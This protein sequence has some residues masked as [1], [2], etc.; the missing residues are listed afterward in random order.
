MRHTLLLASA[1][2]ALM[3]VFV[4]V[5][6]ERMP[7]DATLTRG[8]ESTLRDL[9]DYSFEGT[10]QATSGSTTGDWFVMFYMPGCGHCKS[11]MPQVE[12]LAARHEDHK[13][14]VARVDCSG[15]GQWTCRRFAVKGV[16]QFILL[17]VGK[18]HAYD[19]KRTADVM[20]EW[21]QRVDHEGA[22]AIP[23]EL[24]LLDKLLFFVKFDYDDLLVVYHEY[25]LLLWATGAAFVVLIVLL[26]YLALAPAP[27]RYVTPEGKPIPKAEAEKILAGRKKSPGQAPAAREKRE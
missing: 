5:R 11:A 18:Q 13:V 2:V 9:D 25:P 17:R 7:T 15:N 22:T 20:S 10:T 6:S 14:S 12:E 1:A 4:V 21:L 26:V 23:G 24:G 3:S 16:P 8:L 19:G 27:V